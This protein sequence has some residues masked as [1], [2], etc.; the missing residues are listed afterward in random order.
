MGIQTDRVEGVEA[1]LGHRRGQT[2]L[3]GGET[4]GKSLQK[5]AVTPN[6]SFLD[7]RDREIYR[8]S[9]DWGLRRSYRQLK[10]LNMEGTRPCRSQS[11][12]DKM[13]Q[14]L[15]DPEDILQMWRK[16][17]QSLLNSKSVKR[18]PPILNQIARRPLSLS[19]TTLLGRG[20]TSPETDGGR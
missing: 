8:S 3:T 2:A 11:I 1:R 20:D 6:E 16:Q 9:R 17:F 10:G 19:T 5:T 4:C 13:G 12:R 14:V 18:D 7:A 15:R